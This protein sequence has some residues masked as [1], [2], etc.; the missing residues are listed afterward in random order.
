[1]KRTLKRVTIQETPD[2]WVSLE[3]GRK[4]KTAAGALRGVKRDNAKLAGPD[5]MV[6]T[7]IEWQPTTRTGDMVVRALQG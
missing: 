1:M 5:T 7:V 4:Y 2:G 3:Y 6:I